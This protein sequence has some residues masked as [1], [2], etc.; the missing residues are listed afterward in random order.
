MV[1]FW[2]EF[3]AALIKSAT[4][5]PKL[6]NVAMDVAAIIVAILGIKF[7]TLAINNINIRQAM[8]PLERV[9]KIPAPAIKKPN[10]FCILLP[11]C[12]KHS[13]LIKSI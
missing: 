2:S 7:C 6:N 10:T 1:N 12:I 4:M 5:K 13:R 3:I 8:P 9:K 11:R